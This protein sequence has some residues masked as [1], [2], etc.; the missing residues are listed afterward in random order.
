MLFGYV[1]SFAVFWIST[2]IEKKS[3]DYSLIK[4]RTL[5]DEVCN[6]VDSSAA[7]KKEMRERVQKMESLAGEFLSTNVKLLHGKLVD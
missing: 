5:R 1:W 2:F 4:M 6:D 7:H 3:L